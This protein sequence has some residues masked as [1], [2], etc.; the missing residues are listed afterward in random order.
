VTFWW[1]YILMMTWKAQWGPE[2]CCPS[3]STFRGC[4]SVIHCDQ[5]V[6]W[7]DVDYFPCILIIILKY[8]WPIQWK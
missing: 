7:A 4:Y 5:A 3:Y 2:H 6:A 1:P 8:Y